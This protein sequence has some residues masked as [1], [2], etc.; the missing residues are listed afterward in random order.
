MK[1]YVVLIPLLLIV[2]V[3]AD[4][5]AETTKVLINVVQE[6]GDA[7]SSALIKETEMMI[8]KG[9]L[10]RKYDVMTSDDFSVRSGFT[11]EDV[12]IARS[13]SIPELRKTAAF[14]NAAYIV[15]AK[16]ATRVQQEEVLNMQMNKAV[17]SVAWRIVRTS[18]GGTIDMGSVSFS[19]SGRS[20]GEASAST[21]RKMSE[22]MTRIV[23]GKLP[24]S[25]SAKRAEELGAYKTSLAP[26]QA[27]VATAAAPSPAPVTPAVVAQASGQAPPP[28][29]AAASEGPEIVILN[30]PATR[31][32]IPVVTKKELNIEGMAI[33]PTGISEVRVNGEKVAYDHEG[34][35]THRIDLGANQDH[36]LI[37]AVN[38]AG[39]MASKN[40]ALD[41]MEDKD[42]PEVVLLRPDVTR[43]FE[44]SL[45]PQEKSTMVEGI[46]KDASD[47]LF[48]RVNNQDVALSGNGHFEHKLALDDS[49]GDISI[50][51]AD[52]HGNINRKS[53]RIARGGDG[54]SLSTP[55]VPAGPARKPV[56]WG[57]AVG[58][59]SYSSSSINL[60]YA[61]Q[62]ALNLEKFFKAQQGKSFSEVHF[63]TLVNKDVTRNSIIE[64]ITHHLGQAAPSDV[65]FIFLAGHGT[66]HRQ[67]GSYYFM[68]SDADFDNLLSTGLR[69]SDFEESVNI[70]SKNVDKIIVAMDTCHSGALKV[71]MRGAGGG[72]DLANSINAAS[73]LYIL[74][75]SKAGE[76]SLESDEFKLDPGFSGHGA[77]TYALVTAM[78]GQADYDK[79]HYVS[80]NEMF[81]FV[82]R[83]VPRLTNGQQH[84][85]FRMQ[86]TDLPLIKTN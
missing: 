80:L 68:P 14:N 41:R 79:D 7:G 56:L 64:A 29:E 40:L 82:A 6:Q 83:Q 57:L 18:D 9:L 8:A 74:S 66:Q 48:V 54:W 49:T 10:N 77:F 55:A 5:R 13:G 21:F 23:A 45:P 38:T 53:L 2:L 73:G 17:T 37:M 47:I 15:S 50:E 61:D 59:S 71:G 42:A 78:S 11:R 86:G 32:F 26:K 51:A 58:V 44:V 69:M 4:S 36:V 52:V 20:A 25:L 16:A 67:S 30:P 28:A 75:A 63:K 3:A 39:K 76:A 72:E 19:S 43:G 24:V 33:D 27:P 62:D 84:P 46:V 12:D 85:Y 31:G 22:E 60:K 34:R 70:L 1:K 65:I 81:Q 35:F